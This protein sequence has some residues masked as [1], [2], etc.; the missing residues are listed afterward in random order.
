MNHNP[1][2]NSVNVPPSGRAVV[3]DGASVQENL[4]ERSYLL[5]PLLK[6]ALD[7][8]DIKLEDE[9]NRFRAKQENG[10]SDTETTSMEAIPAGN[11]PPMGVIW[12]QHSVD[13]DPE[14][15]ILTAE[16]VQ[17][18]SSRTTSEADPAEQSPPS[19]QPEATPVGGF[20]IIDGLTTTTSNS[21]SAIPNI[22][23]APIALHR[24]NPLASHENLNLNF[25]LGGAIDPFHDEYSS[26]SQ[27]LL[28][29]I[30]SGY[31]TADPLNQP[32]EP[33][34]TEPKRKYLTPLKIG[35]M[36]AA[37]VLV[38]G[39]VYTYLNP[40]ILAPSTATKVVTSTA[41]TNSLGQL[42]QSPNLA[43][44]EFTELNLSALNTIKLPTTATTTNV[45]TVTPSTVNATQT[46]AA[47]APVAIP[48]NGR[49]VIPPT[50]ITSQ[51]RLADS[52]VRS[53]LPPNF[54]SLAKPSG[55]RTAPSGIGR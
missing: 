21:R 11:T 50:T 55:Y 2:D 20:V 34:A 36:A 26:S 30:Q 4:D 15:E 31:P 9:L 17:P 44:N 23:Y 38:G 3:A 45:T 54:H 53:L 43:V 48:F 46:G 51:P 42:I 12:E 7:C 22:N 33:A 52:L 49:Q 37:C 10:S 19:S 40:S 6:Q 5:N 14:T 24:G 25:S 39:A 41:T 27:E 32:P 47:T 35:S 29:Q 16:I 8:L 13:F 1:S 18:G 28:R